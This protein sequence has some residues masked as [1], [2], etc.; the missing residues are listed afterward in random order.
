M[1]AALIIAAGKTSQKEVFRPEKEIGTISAI[2]RIALLF[3]QTG[4]RRIVVVCGNDDSKAEKLVPHM[5]LIFLQNP[6]TGEMLDSIKTGLSYLQD[7]CTQVLISPVDVPLFSVKTVRSLMTSKSDVCV[8]SYQGR[9]GHPILLQAEHFSK[10]LSYIGEGGLAGAIRASGLHRQI[11]EIDDKGILSNV[12]KEEPPNELILHHDLSEV[13]P[14]FRFRL[15]KE[16]PFYG[17]GAHQLL[18]L[19]KETGSLSKACRYM[20]ISYS[21]G[22]KIIFTLEQQFGAPVIEGHQGGKDGGFSTITADAEKLIQSYDAFCNE[23]EQVLQNLF[24]KYFNP[25]SPEE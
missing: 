3:Q 24:Q 12:Q 2:Q 15:H 4:I 7:K 8:P 16:R 20:G 22:R 6:S 14:S 23:A 5:N 11:I 21:K 1:T 19:V 9:N 17:P 18:Q 13:R 25:Q 10:V